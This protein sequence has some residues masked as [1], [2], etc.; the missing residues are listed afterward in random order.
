MNPKPTKQNPYQFS[1][2]IGRHSRNLYSALMAMVLDELLRKTEQSIV[3]V[4]NRIEVQRA[5]VAKMESAGSEVQ[6]ARELLR[7]LQRSHLTLLVH[8]KQLLRG[9][10]RSPARGTRNDLQRLAARLVEKSARP[11]DDESE[12]RMRVVRH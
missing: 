2:S 12:I 7:A 1:S 11:I 5:I 9:T 4:E 10:L 8:W 3:D 6:V